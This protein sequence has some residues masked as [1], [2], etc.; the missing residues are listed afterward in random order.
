[1]KKLL[2][3]GDSITDSFHNFDSD[4]LGEGYVRQ[5]AESLHYGQGTVRV[6]NKG[7]DG[8]TVPLLLRLLKNES[9]AWEAPDCL[10]VLIGV[11]DAGVMMSG[12]D[13]LSENGPARQ[14][15]DHSSEASETDA[16]D[17]DA[18]RCSSRFTAG[19]DDF[20]IGFKTLIEM[21]RQKT[22]C[23]IFIMEPFIFSYPAEYA[24]WR[25][26]LES[27]AKIEREEAAR[28][29]LE[30]LPL[31]ESLDTAVR[32]QGA[33]AV[34]VDGIHLTDEGH[35]ILSA[36]WLRAYFRKFGMDG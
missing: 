4:G 34:T 31:Q 17:T 11:N 1:M 20:R 30:F 29:G 33:G 14:A 18:F 15:A 22:S 23:P 12:A 16:E 5:I 6:S 21:L 25:P 10:T 7:I 36:V 19:L 2:F 9:A 27:L 28:Y 24:L 3:L 32:A 8:F 26:L 35:R 13:V